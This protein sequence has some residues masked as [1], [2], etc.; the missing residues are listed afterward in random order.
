MQNTFD[1]LVIGTLRVTEAVTL[2]NGAV[3]NVMIQAGAD[4]DA[5]KI[6]AFWSHS[7]GIAGAATTQTRVI[8]IGKAVGTL[9]HFRVTQVSA[10]TGAATV[11]VDLKKNGTTV[12]DAVITLNAATAAYA[13]QDAVF[14]DDDI[15]EDDVFAVV[16]TVTATGTD[17]AATGIGWQLDATEVYV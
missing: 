11:T 5:S 3:T 6:E 2:P 7:D 15:A 12:L 16:V 8:A 1:N 10:C 4:I 14:D 17:T 9:I 13:V